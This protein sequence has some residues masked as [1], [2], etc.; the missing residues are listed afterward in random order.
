MY[1]KV[2]LTAK[3]VSVSSATWPKLQLEKSPLDS[4]SSI[5]VIAITWKIKIK[6][7]ALFNNTPQSQRQINKHLL[8]Y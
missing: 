4:H 7:I 6:C 5:P 1:F 8:S 2:N 3:P